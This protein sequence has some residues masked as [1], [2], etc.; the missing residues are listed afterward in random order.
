[1]PAALRTWRN[2]N[3][4]FCYLGGPGFYVMPEISTEAALVTLFTAMNK[5]N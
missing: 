5:Q 2:I 3:E 1:M 4:A